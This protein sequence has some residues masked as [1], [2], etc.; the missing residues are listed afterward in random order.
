[1][2]K[3]ELRKLVSEYK[4][5]KS[6]QIDEYDLSR[7]HIKSKKLKEMEQRY[8]HETGNLIESDLQSSNVDSD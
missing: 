8:S 2:K 6:K 5:L 4:A 7:N 1:M 3:S